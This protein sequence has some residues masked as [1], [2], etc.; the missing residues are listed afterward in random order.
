[1]ETVGEVGRG[2]LT[3]M[4]AGRARNCAPA[5]GAQRTLERC[6]TT[7]STWGGGTGIYSIACLQKNPLLRAVVW[8]RAGGLESRSRDGRRLRP[9][10]G[11]L[12]CCAG[13]MFRGPVPRRLRRHFVVQHS[14]RLG[15]AAVPRAPAGA[16][17]P[18]RCP[19]E[20]VCSSMMRFIDDDMDGAL[21]CGAVFG[22]AF[23]ISLR[24]APTAP[25]SIVCG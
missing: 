2:H 22:G 8:D 21:G 13:D 1:M 12:E 3:M 6:T 16:F 4:L 18:P 10:A 20:A 5:A 23:S 14:P 9:S 17:A 15:R 19:P 7:A 24:A 25:P 11:R